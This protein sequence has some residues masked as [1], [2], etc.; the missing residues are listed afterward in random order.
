MVLLLD[1][2]HL[3]DP[4]FVTGLARDLKARGGG[5]VL[6]HGSGERGERALEALG[7]VP[8]N[9]GGAWRTETPDQA[10]VVEQATRA[11]S[12]ELAHELNEAGVASVRVVGADRGLLKARG[13]GVEAGKTGWLQ[14]LV[15]Q[16]VVVVVASLVGGA[17]AETLVEADPA[18]AAAALAG[19]LGEPVT[20]LLKKR[21]PEGEGG[22]SVAAP[23]VR[24]A[25]GDADAAARLVGSGASVVAVPRGAV[26]DA[27]GPGGAAVGA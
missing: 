6:V 20:V 2:Y 8:A 23:P 5:A 27:G 17:A 4:L 12:R 25:L 7:L 10:A 24:A 22:V 26:R 9:E 3:G 19:A 18:A 21:L 16:G 1:A 11:L 14:T 15:G 13:G